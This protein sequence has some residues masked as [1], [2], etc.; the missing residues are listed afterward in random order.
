MGKSKLE[1]NRFVELLGE[2]GKKIGN[3]GGLIS[4]FEALGGKD[5]MMVRGKYSEVK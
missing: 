5:K 4:R 2:R 3:E 1:R